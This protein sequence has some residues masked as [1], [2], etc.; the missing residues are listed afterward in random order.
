M[1]ELL[2]DNDSLNC[3]PYNINQ[4]DAIFILYLFYHSTSICFGHIIAQHQEVSLYIYN[5]WYS[6]YVLLECPLARPE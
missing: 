6:L 1:Y 4:L 2:D 5:N 3:G